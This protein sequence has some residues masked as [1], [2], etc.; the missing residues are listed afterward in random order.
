[1]R[2][3]ALIGYIDDL[4]YANELRYLDEIY[5][6]LKPS[7]SSSSIRAQLEIVRAGGGIAVLPR[8]MAETGEPGLVRILAREAVIVRTFWMSARREV[9]QTARVKRVRKWIRE[10][11]ERKKNVLQI[12]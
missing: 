8:F 1:M 9:Q 4:L 11:V 6:A 3:H 2:E 5:P 10:T 7:I 12:G